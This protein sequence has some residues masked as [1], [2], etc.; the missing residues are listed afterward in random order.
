MELR[1]A[2]APSPAAVCSTNAPHRGAGGGQAAGPSAGTPAPPHATPSTPSRHGSPDLLP[3]PAWDL[4]ARVGQGVSRPSGQHVVRE[5]DGVT[6]DHGSSPAPRRPCAAC[7]A[8]PAHAANRS[9]PRRRNPERDGRVTP[10]GRRRP[11]PLRRTAAPAAKHGQPASLSRP[12]TRCPVL[13][14]GRATG[15]LGSGVSV[16]G[17]SQ[18]QSHR[19]IST[20]GPGRRVGGNG[21]EAPPRTGAPHPHSRA[22]GHQEDRGQ[23]SVKMHQLHLRS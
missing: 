4:E 20:A 6:G 19:H 18:C 17:D 7:K 23:E 1:T 16:A 21:S 9:P 14:D 5:V 8:T 2:A 3:P 13:D 11:V 22:E 10:W 15:A 12:H